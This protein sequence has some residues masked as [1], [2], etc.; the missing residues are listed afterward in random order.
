[1]AWHTTFDIGDTS[2]AQSCSR[3][4][5]PSSRYP[6]NYESKPQNSPAH[7]GN[8]VQGLRANF[9]PNADKQRI[10]TE[11]STKYYADHVELWCDPEGKDKSTAGSFEFKALVENTVYRCLY[12]LSSRQFFSSGSREISQSC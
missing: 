7:I 11:T 10:Q 1:M 4:Y 9:I 8:L 6:Q 2:K 3:S 12:S 5:R